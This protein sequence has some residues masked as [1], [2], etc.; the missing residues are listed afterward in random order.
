MQTD[1]QDRQ[2]T[3]SFMTNVARIAS[4]HV[5]RASTQAS[6]ST[7]GGTQEFSSLENLS[8]NCKIL[9]SFLNNSYLRKSTE[10]YQYYEASLTTEN[11]Q[12][13]VNFV[14]GKLQENHVRKLQLSVSYLRG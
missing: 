3:S 14:V 11:L 1:H 10:N 5:G 7:T 2:C 12:K 4:Q 8:E 9:S 13:T 6:S